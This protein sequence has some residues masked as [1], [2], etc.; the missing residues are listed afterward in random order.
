MFWFYRIK[1]AIRYWIFQDYL[2][3]KSE[4]KLNEKALALKISGAIFSDVKNFYRPKD[5]IHYRTYI[6]QRN[7]INTHFDNCGDLLK[8]L[9]EMSERI[10]DLSKI[11]PKD[12]RS[13]RGER[14]MALSDWLVNSDGYVVSLVDFYK[15]FDRLVS[16]NESLL[17]RV[18][19][20]SPTNYSYLC[21]RH[22]PILV[23]IPSVI[24]A[25]YKIIWEK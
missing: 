10:E 15:E 21:R 25:L 3:G 4:N 18:K 6:G 19:E 13:N 11:P 22:L 12:A 8:A 20:V 1:V 23:E 2:K 5:F 24:T 14:T 9:Q 16:H 7:C 17:L